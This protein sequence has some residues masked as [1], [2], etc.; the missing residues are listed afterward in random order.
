M[1]YGLPIDLVAHGSA[2]LCVLRPRSAESPDKC[3]HPRHG[4]REID[5]VKLSELCSGG[6]YCGHDKD[7]RNPDRQHGV[8]P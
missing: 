6:N 8:E 4:K 2:S 7:G 1:V 3:V 5:A